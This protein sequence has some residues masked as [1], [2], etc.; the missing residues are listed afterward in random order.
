[1]PT[2]VYSKGCPFKFINRGGSSA[3]ATGAWA[4]ADIQQRVP[5]TRPEISLGIKVSICHQKYQ[6]FEYKFH[7]LSKNWEF[8][9]QIEY[10]YP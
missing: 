7:F 6:D 2:K 5:G 1:M 8:L 10:S 9:N 3:G 4:P